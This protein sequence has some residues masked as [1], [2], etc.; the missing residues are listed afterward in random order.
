MPA[1]AAELAHRAP[2]GRAAGHRHRV[3]GR[4]PLPPRAVPCPDLPAGD[5]PELGEM[6][7][8]DPLADEPFDPAPLAEVLADPDVEIVLHAGRQDV[9]LLRAAVELRHPQRL[10]HAGRRRASRGMRAQLSY[11]GLLREVLGVRL[12]KTASFTRWDRRPL[13]PSSWSTRA[14]TCCT[15]SRWPR[16][17]RTGCARAAAWTGRARSAVRWSTSATTATSTRSSG[18]CRA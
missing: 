8:L 13:S 1:V 5:D 4:G 18:G 17:C 14:R 2:R 7:L 6:T 10:R 11:E 15:C 3:H 16:P 12:R 9:A